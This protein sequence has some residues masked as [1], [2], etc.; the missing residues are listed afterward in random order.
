M[1]ITEY[2]VRSD[3]AGGGNGTTDSASGANAA[4]TWAEL[5]TRMSAGAAAAGDR[6]NIKSG[7]YSISATDT[8]TNDGTV[9]SPIIFRGFNS[10]IG[11]LDSQGRTSAQQ[12]LNLTN[13]PL[14]SYASGTRLNASG[15]DFTI[16]Q[17]LKLT[18]AGTG[19]AGPLLNGAGNS[20]IYRCYAENI[21]TSASAVGISGGIVIDC[22]AALTGASGGSAAISGTVV[23]GCRV[24]QSQATGINPNNSTSV[25]LDNVVAN[26]VN[27]IVFSATTVG[28]RFCAIGNTVYNCS[29]NGITIA[30]AAYTAIPLIS[31]N[32][33]V[34]DCG[35]NGFY[36]N[37]DGTGQ[38]AAVFGFNRTRDNV[39]AAMNGWDDWVSATTFSHVT[40]DTGGAETDFTNAGSNDYTLISAAPA[41]GTGLQPYTDIGALQR[42][43]AAAGGGS[44]N[45]ILGG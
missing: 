20:V 8:W 38:L 37:Y 21:S 36:S 2:Y 15:A 30:S 39:T 41:K 40:T 24:I 4:F 34:T 19:I 25:A 17:N 29:S 10:I 26:C 27:G 5:G 45:V 31:F 6:Y 16:F 1:A 18:V 3:S 44:R 43:E 11:D 22:D 7:T 13:F 28:S 9:V 12:A 32:N 42:Q 35:A 14:L 33:H 23:I